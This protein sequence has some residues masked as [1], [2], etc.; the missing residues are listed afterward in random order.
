MWA[1]M[2]ML[3]V[4]SSA[5]VLAIALISGKKGGGQTASFFAKLFILLTTGNEQ[6]RDWPRPSD[7]YLPFSLSPYPDY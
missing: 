4:F 1:M 6:R 7:E 3:R 5:T 2:P